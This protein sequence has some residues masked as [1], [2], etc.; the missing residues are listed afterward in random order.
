MSQL[1]KLL[2]LVQARMSLAVTRFDGSRPIGEMDM[3]WNEANECMRIGSEGEQSRWEAWVKEEMIAVK[4]APIIGTD[5]HE[6]IEPS[7]GYEEAPIEGVSLAIEWVHR[8]TSGPSS[9]GVRFAF[10]AWSNRHYV[11]VPGAVYDGNRFE[12]QALS[13]APCW[14]RLAERG[15]HTPAFIT[16]IP[17]LNP[18]E[19]PSAIHLLTGDASTPAL[20]WHDPARKLG[21]LVL[22]DQRTEWGETSIHIEES[23]DRERCVSEFRAPGGRPLRKYEMCTT[24]AP[25]SDS[26]ASFVDGS[27]V[28]MRVNVFAFPCENVTG[29]FRAFAEAR[30]S[31][32]GPPTLVPGLPFSAAWDIQQSKYNAMNWR[33]TYGYYAVGT[34]D[35]KHQDWQ[36]GWVGGGMSSLALLA[37][38]DDLSAER[39]ARTVDFMLSGQTE[40]GFFPGVFY[41]GRWYGD[42]FNDDPARDCPEQWHIVRKSADALYFLLK[43]AAIIERRGIPDQVPASW[44]AGIRRLADGFL[45]LWERYGQF[46]QWI[47][48]DTGEML[49][50]GSAGGAMAIGG[51]ALAAQWLDDDRYRRAAQA[52]GDY[53][54]AHFTAK[55]VT[56]GGPGEILQCP[57][58]E[59]AFALLESFVVLYETTG[60]PRWLAKAEEAALQAISWCVSYDFAFPPDST[61]GRLGMRTAGSVIANAQNKHSA[62]GI[63]T[64]SGD[65]LFKLFRATGKTLY[66]AQLRDTAHNLTQ[67]LS[68]A[69]RPVRGWD[70]VEM[71]PGYMSERVN[72]SDWEGQ[73]LVGEAL[74]LSCWCE[75]SLMLAHAEVPGVYVQPDTRFVWSADHVDCE[76]AESERETVLR[77]HNQTAFQAVVKLLAESGRDAATPLGAFAADDWARIAIGAG[78]TR[79]VPLTG[80][81]PAAGATFVA[82]A[83]NPVGRGDADDR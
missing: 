20:G 61:F 54:Y 17:R 41:N 44:R 35:Q 60:E 28:R 49:V 68:R 57:D 53:Y 71:P 83:A 3:D 2:G 50:G 32:T 52:A 5:A 22:T 21:F 12:A 25:S 76:L 9:V 4:R 67:Y 78:E 14:S 81:M 55:G 34:V 65:A 40:A 10:G 27:I 73:E 23:D 64:L 62:P 31:L 38:G 24:E 45:A 36:I 66:L 75:A 11:L 48:A 37:D 1:N 56:T 47:R 74:P 16:D 7:A 13:Y 29:L 33:E 15:P 69:D 80:G 30:M 59:S 43:H 18:S 39:A 51:L 19:G 72:M 70:G 46:G 8:G 63:C 82:G 6:G 58:S 77:L 42:E 79:E 26:G